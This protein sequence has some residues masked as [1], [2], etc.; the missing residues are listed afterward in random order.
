MRL[1]P[2]LCSISLFYGVRNIRTGERLGQGIGFSSLQNITQDTTQTTTQA[3][4][5]LGSPILPIAPYCLTYD[6][7]AVIEQW[8]T[9]LLCKDHGMGV[10]QKAQLWPSFF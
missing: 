3:N 2:F 9:I 10:A 8:Y 7:E 1:S 4:S 5:L 6:G